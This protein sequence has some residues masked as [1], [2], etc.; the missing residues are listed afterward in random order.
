[1]AIARQFPF[2]PT[3]QLW[4]GVFRF[5]AV[6]ALPALTIAGI[7]IALTLETELTPIS[8]L[9]ALALPCLWLFGWLLMVFPARHA[10][11]SS[12]QIYVNF[13]GFLA[14]IVKTNLCFA[15]FGMLLFSS[16]ELGH[17]EAAI[18][19][20]FLATLFSLTLILSLWFWRYTS[21]PTRR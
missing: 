2:D 8:I 3:R 20:Y 5:H 12:Q 6:G 1:M 11:Y 7:L 18:E 9:R 4:K 16:I 15:V 17:D 21:R 14:V 19:P 10:P 13:K